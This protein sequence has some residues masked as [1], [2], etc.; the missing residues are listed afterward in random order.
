MKKAQ[1]YH[2]YERYFEQGKYFNTP[3]NK[4]LQTRFDTNY[5]QGASSFTVSFSRAVRSLLGKNLIEVEYLH[6]NSWG[7]A[8]IQ[9][10][11]VK[12]T[13]NNHFLDINNNKI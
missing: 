12:L 7:S 4:N 2:L 13:V 5:L 1:R 6:N 3:E 9:I 10:A 8:K 11:K